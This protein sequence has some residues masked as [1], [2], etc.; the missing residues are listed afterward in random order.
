MLEYLNKATKLDSSD[1]FA[2]YN[3]ACAHCL[4]N[5]EEDALDA[6]TVAIGLDP[7]NIEEMQKEEDLKNIHKNKRIIHFI[8]QYH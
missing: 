2:W 7:D 4:L 8:R 1:D 6:I 3:K 5:Q